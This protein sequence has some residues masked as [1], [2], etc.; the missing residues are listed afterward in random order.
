ME[1]NTAGL[2]PA[3][4][5]GCQSSVGPVYLHTQTNAH[6]HKVEYFFVNKQTCARPD[7]VQPQ[8]TVEHFFH[9]LFIQLQILS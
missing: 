9:F 8:H 4:K 2:S 6:T 1:R 5:P 7:P 3:E